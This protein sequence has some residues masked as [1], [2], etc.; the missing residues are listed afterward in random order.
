MELLKAMAKSY[1]KTFLVAAWTAVMLS[2]ILSAEIVLSACAIAATVLFSPMS[3]T[4][5]VASIIKSV[6]RWAASGGKWS[7]DYTLDIL[8]ASAIF[9]ISGFLLMWGAQEHLFY[10]AKDLVHG[11]AAAF[12]YA[13]AEKEHEHECA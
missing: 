10:K 1:A 7:P 3:L 2:C 5:L 6:N 12:K 11:T 8:D 4:M 13:A 9:F